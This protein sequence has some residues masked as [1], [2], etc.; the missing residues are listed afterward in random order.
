[1]PTKKSSHERTVKRIN[2]FFE[3]GFQLFAGAAF[4]A[5]SFYAIFIELANFYS[6]TF[7]L[8]NYGFAI[9]LGL[10]STC[11]S[12]ARNVP[13]QDI[14]RAN[15]INNIA[16]ESLYAAIIFLLGSAFKY[17]AVVKGNKFIE[18]IFD[19]ASWMNYIPKAL[20]FIC[21]LKAIMNFS[22]VV[23]EILRIIAVATDKNWDNQ[24]NRRK[25]HLRK[26]QN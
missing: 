7:G 22:N 21:F 25:E 11:F 18:I 24:I 16:L 5:V 26:D 15:E 13:P 4:Q 1:M 3:M 10:A 9:M 17:T 6:D 19:K 23:T 20:A 2:H 8:T 14:N 12:W